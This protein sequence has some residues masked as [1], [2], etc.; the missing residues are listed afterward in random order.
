[1]TIAQKVLD[2]VIPASVTSKL[3]NSELENLLKSYQ[4]TKSAMNDFIKGHLTWTE[5]LELLELHQ[6]NIDSYLNNLDH[7][8]HQIGLN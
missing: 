3:N 5:Y 4:L 7:N 8:L 1:M 2:L 6:V